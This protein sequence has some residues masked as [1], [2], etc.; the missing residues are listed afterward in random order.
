MAEIN[1]ELAVFQ[2]EW[3]GKIL[4]ILDKKNLVIWVG[5]GNS[6]KMT[7]ITKNTLSREGMDNIKSAIISELKK[8]LHKHG[9]EIITTK[10]QEKKEIKEIKK[11]TK[12]VLKQNTRCC[13]HCFQEF[14]VSITNKKKKYCSNACKT[15][16]WKEKNI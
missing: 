10:S 5:H 16:H 15:A 8:E 3:I 13:E 1:S 4:K 6:H 14:N 7:N 11:K 9:L 2:K 12:S